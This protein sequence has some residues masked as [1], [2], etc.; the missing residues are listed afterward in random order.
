M[1][2]EYILGYCPYETLGVSYDAIDDDIKKNFRKL[3]IKYHPDKIGENN[4]TTSSN[5]QKIIES[6]NMLICPLKR[7]KYD[8]ENNIN[9]TKT[10]FT[11]F[12]DAIEDLFSN[13]PPDIFNR[14]G[15]IYNNITTSKEL[16]LCKSIYNSLPEEL[17]FKLGF[18]KST[19]IYNDLNGGLNFLLHKYNELNEIPEMHENFQRDVP[20]EH[21]HEPEPE[22]EPEP[23][24]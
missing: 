11:S 18:I 14:I 21:E 23:G 19:D 12:E 22:S 7:K 4:D 20:E 15:T 16:K 9:N 8:Y 24:T 2:N 13:A 1:N 3:I 17:R 6:Y 5:A 10:R